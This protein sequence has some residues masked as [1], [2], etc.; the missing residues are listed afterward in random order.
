[1]ADG[2]LPQFQGCIPLWADTTNG[3]NGT[4]P[5]GT[6]IHLPFSGFTFPAQPSF[7]SLVACL[8][9]SA[10]F[11]AMLLVLALLRKTRR[12]RE[13]CWLL[14]SAFNGVAAELLKDMIGQP[15]PMSCLTSCGMPSGHSSYS[16]GFLCL[17]VQDLAL[18]PPLLT[19]PQR[20]GRAATMAALLLPVPP[21]P[22]VG[23]SLPLLA[24]P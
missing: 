2:P 18:G 6:H 1:M 3:T 4:C 20:L 9:S 16:V 7:L 23:C 15:R 24:P 19:Q 17:L 10:P 12:P 21:A 11:L 14:Y 5:Y 22:P 8:Y 13:V